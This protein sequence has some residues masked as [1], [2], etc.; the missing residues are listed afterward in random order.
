MTITS[1]VRISAGTFSCS[2]RP[3]IF[4]ASWRPS[5][6]TR[7]S[8]WSRI[9]PRPARTRRVLGRAAWTLAKASII[10]SGPY[11]GLSH[12]TKP[13]V[14]IGGGGGAWAPVGFDGEAASA[15]GAGDGVTRGS[16]GA[17]PSQS[18]DR[19]LFVLE[20]EPSPRPSPGVPGEGGR[21]GSGSDGA[22][23]SRGGRTPFV[24]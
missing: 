8:S 14:T 10:T 9:S 11:L 5:S 12:L 20:S 6:A 13:K 16:G 1:N 19:A 2:T 24:V 22:S 7:A 3:R 4:T 23:A 18:R 17:S 15:A 21:G